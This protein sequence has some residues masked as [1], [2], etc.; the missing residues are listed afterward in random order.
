MNH[1]YHILNGDALKERFPNSLSGSL[2]IMRECL[3]DG[4]VQ[5]SNMEDF[6]ALRAQFISHN[7]GGTVQNYYDK[8]FPELE[9]VKAIPNNAEVNLWFEDDLFC[10]VN[11]WFIV[12]LLQKQET[13]IKINLVRPEVHSQY[14]FSRFSSEELILLFE[15]RIRLEKLDTIASLWEAYQ[16]KRPKELFE[17]A[18]ALSDKYPFILDAVNAHLDRLP[19]NGNPGRPI[20]SLKRIMKELGTNEFGP[21]FQA[22]NQQESIY[23]FGD[24]QVKILYDKIKK[25]A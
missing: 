2:I 4:E 25:G 22:F 13:S 21:I 6:L 23:G 24:L 10:Q 9:K 8:F 3:V 12:H 11:L 5:A 7:Y 15:K 16:H 18:E 19:N 14:G 1:P 20:T 17:I